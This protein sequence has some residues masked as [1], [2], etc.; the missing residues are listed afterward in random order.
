[1]SAEEGAQRTALRPL[2]AYG[3]RLALGV[4]L[5]AAGLLRFVGLGDIERP[6][7]D[8]KY[9]VVQAQERVDD[10]EPV[11]TPAHPPLGTWL[12]AGGIALAGDDPVG[13]RLVPAAAGV[14]AVGLTYALAWAVWRRRWW[15][16]AAAALVAVDGLAVVTSRVA[17]LDGL[18]VPFALGA[19]L[20]LWRWRERPAGRWALAAAGACIGAVTAI[21]WNGLL[22]APVAVAV[23]ASAE[24]SARR[25][26]AGLA[27]AGAVAAAVYVGSYTSWFV[28]YEDTETAQERCDDG[29]CGTAA[30]D[31]VASWFWE[32]GDRVRFHRELEA[33]HPDRSHP[34]TW[35]AMAEPVTVYQ[36]RCA[37]PLPAGAECPYGLD[38]TRSIVTVGNPVLWWGG[39]LAALPVLAFAVRRR[40]RGT[41]LVVGT[42]AALYLPWFASPKPGF[43]YFLTPAVPFLA[44]TLVRAV[45]ALPVRRS[46][47]VAAVIG[48]A[49][50]ACAVWLA[51]LWFGWPL[52]PGELDARRWLPGWTP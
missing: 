37:D 45:T 13:W 28:D 22:L 18:Q 16:V 26:L 8:E 20:A 42:L 2:V 52:D 49:V 30:G 36:A 32:Q 39:F 25:K 12:I 4:V 35:P 14:A 24:A 6:Y 23:V 10:L 40:D 27:M 7:F 15:A 46:R 38:E 51:P 48:V 44:L 33:T 19:V 9:Y 31:R 50:V 5:V 43:Q 3:P 17:I 11:D 47:I 29:H 41:L 21:K 1:M 34:V